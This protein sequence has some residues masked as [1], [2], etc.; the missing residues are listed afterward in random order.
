VLPQNL[1]WHT[2]EVYF[3]QEPLTWYLAFKRGARTSKWKRR[4]RQSK[5]C[6][7]LCNYKIFSLTRQY[8]ELLLELPAI[9][10]VFRVKST[11]HR[12]KFWTTPVDSSPLVYATTA[13]VFF[14]CLRR[15]WSCRDVC[16]VDSNWYVVAAETTCYQSSTKQGLFQPLLVGR[17]QSRN[18][19]EQ[20]TRE[21]LE[22]ESIYRR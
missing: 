10:V 6:V 4:L 2:A 11:L 1:C 22:R 3:P 9:P 13:L 19:L 20:R 8:T 15:Y 16:I 7:T 18:T 14:Y 5:Y 21:L 12:R 17:W